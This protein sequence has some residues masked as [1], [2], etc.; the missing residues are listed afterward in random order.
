MSVASAAETKRLQHATSDARR[1]ATK[2]YKSPA[3]NVY[4]REGS[5]WDALYYNC[6]A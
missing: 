5:H 6:R 4:A 3:G 2:L 1:D